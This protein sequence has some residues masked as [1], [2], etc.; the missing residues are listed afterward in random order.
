MAQASNA[1]Q[2]VPAEN[3]LIPVVRAVGTCVIV[4]V[5]WL[6]DRVVAGRLPAGS[7]WRY[8]IGG[9]IVAGGLIAVLSFSDR[10]NRK[11]S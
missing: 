1:P 6:I 9:V 8:V 2:E 4:L 11:N 10:L 7:V 3:K 5:L